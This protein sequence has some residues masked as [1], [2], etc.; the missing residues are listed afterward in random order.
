VSVFLNVL[1][2]AGIAGGTALAASALIAWAGGLPRSMQVKAGERKP[3]CKS[4]CYSGCLILAASSRLMPGPAA[5]IAASIAGCLACV[6]F[7]WELRA[8]LRS[9]SG[10]DHVS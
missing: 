1:T 7:I 3:L 10:P 8:Q 5:L 2:W 9:R 6:V 4:L